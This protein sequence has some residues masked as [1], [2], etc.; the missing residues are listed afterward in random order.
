M[1]APIETLYVDASGSFIS[2]IPSIK[3]K[4]ENPK[5]ILVYAVTI[6]HPT[7]KSP[8]VAFFEYITTYYNIVFVR[9]LFLKLKKM[10]TKLFDY[11]K[12]SARVGMGLTKSILQAVLQEYEDKNLESYPTRMFKIATYI[13]FIHENKKT[14]L[15][16]SSF[17]FLTMN[18]ESIQKLFG[19]KDD[20]VK[21]N[22]CMEIIGR[23]ICCQGLD[24]A[25]EICKLATIVMK[26]EK[27]TTVVEK[28]V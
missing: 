6:K 22:F 20:T 12:T 1:I 16:I 10:E 23:L 4:D 19:K 11:S 7:D 26:N 18:R 5:R 25:I 17:H 28:S 15:C 8:P 21:G 9:Q 24:G 3:N 14:R 2:P 13:S 27:A